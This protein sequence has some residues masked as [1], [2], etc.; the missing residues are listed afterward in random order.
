MLLTSSGGTKVSS[1]VALSYDVECT[2]AHEIKCT[3]CH[4]NQTHTVSVLCHWRH[5]CQSLAKH[6]TLAPL[7]YSFSKRS[8]WSTSGGNVSSGPREAAIMATL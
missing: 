7:H 6:T 8:I 4:H 2:V 3:S 1:H 5:C